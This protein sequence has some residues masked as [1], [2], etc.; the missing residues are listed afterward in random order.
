MEETEPFFQNV[1][2]SLNAY[3]IILEFMKTHEGSKNWAVGKLLE[4]VSEHIS[5]IHLSPDSQK[6]ES[7]IS[8]YGL[9]NRIITL[10]TYQN[11]NNQ[12]IMLKHLDKLA[13]IPPLS[14]SFI[15]DEE[16]EQYYATLCN[17]DLEMINTIMEQNSKIGNMGK[18]QTEALRMLIIDLNDRV[19]SN[20][21]GIIFQ[22]YEN[23]MTESN[24]SKLNESLFSQLWEHK[25]KFNEK[26]LKDFTF[27]F[28]KDFINKQIQMVKALLLLV[29]NPELKM[30]KTKIQDIFQTDDL[31]TY[32]E[33]MYYNHMYQ[34][35]I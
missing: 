2:R 22:I 3:I 33:N 32:I 1:F 29:K 15:G 9:C 24:D 23:I 20:N 31:S 28:T 34:I 16:L 18:S 26:K 25:S 19:N 13:I 14:V 11:P 4:T 27:Q 7:V 35:Y 5:G 10:F 8:I 6:A 12:K 17:P 21:I 30:A